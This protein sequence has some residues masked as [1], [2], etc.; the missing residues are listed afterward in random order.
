MMKLLKKLLN[1]ILSPLI[2]LIDLPVIPE[3]LVMIV[4]Q[5]FEY[6]RAGVG[7]FNLICPL[8]L[9][10]PAINIFLAVY[11]F[12]HGYYIVMWVVKKIPMLGIT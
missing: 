7:F 5:T 4:N 11:I 8:E 6:M 10:Q 2:N 1:L 3:E 12:E 9:I